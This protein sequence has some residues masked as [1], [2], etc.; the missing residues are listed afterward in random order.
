[1]KNLF[2]VLATL[3]LTAC[4]DIA[5]DNP[6][7]FSANVRDGQIIGTYNPA[8]WTS[9]EIQT[10]SR[11]DCATGEIANYS[12]TPQSNGLIAFVIDCA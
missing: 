3:G 10:F 4:G 6:N 12:E 8:G 9:D 7:A 11:N 5:S 2:L 1:M